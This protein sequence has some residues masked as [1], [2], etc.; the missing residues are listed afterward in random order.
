MLVL[1]IFVIII[2]SFSYSQPPFRPALFLSDPSTQ[3]S[4]AAQKSS[5]EPR[6]EEAE[7]GPLLTRSRFIA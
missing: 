2:V 6:P 1:I 4:G 7:Q 3:H 5:G